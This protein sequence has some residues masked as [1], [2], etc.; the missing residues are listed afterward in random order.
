LLSTLSWAP[1][2]LFAGLIAAYMASRTTGI[3]WLAPETE[4]ADVVGLVTKVIEALGLVFALKLIQPWAPN[5]RP[6]LRR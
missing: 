5:R 3:P 1:A 2:L 4:P 6:R